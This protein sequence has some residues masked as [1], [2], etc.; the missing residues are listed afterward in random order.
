MKYYLEFIPDA[1][2][3]AIEKYNITVNDKPEEV[4]FEKCRLLLEDTDSIMVKGRLK[5]GD[6][7]YINI[8]VC[9][10]ENVLHEIGHVFDI[11][12]ANDYYLS[13]TPEFKKIF[14]KECALAEYDEY[15]SKNTK[16]YFAE[17]F[18]D[19]CLDYELM[20]KNRPLTHAYIKRAVES[21]PESNIA[22][23]VKIEWD[24]NYFSK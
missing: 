1:V 23:Q 6:I 3:L 15:L 16:E 4:T 14:K 22:E 20:E 18:V 7:A 13:G 17:S 12:G 9:S 10:K 21:L 19:Y 11:K 24:K 2:L 8:F 5:S